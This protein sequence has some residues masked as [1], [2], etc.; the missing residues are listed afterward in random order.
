MAHLSYNAMLIL[1]LLI[2][3]LPFAYKTSMRVG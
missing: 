2:L 1:H 3:P